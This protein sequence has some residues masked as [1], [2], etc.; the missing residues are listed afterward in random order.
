MRNRDSDH[1]EYSGKTSNIPPHVP[2]PRYV[3]GDPMRNGRGRSHQISVKPRAV[4]SRVTVTRNGFRL[5]L[6]QWE[7]QALSVLFIHRPT[8]VH[9]I[10]VY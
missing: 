8:T 9:H 3:G 6:A 1:R 7:S 4:M 10:G 2:P 5:E